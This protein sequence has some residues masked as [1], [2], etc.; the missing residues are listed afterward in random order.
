MYYCIRDMQY[1]IPQV[2]KRGSAPMKPAGFVLIVG[3]LI[4]VPLVVFAQ[5]SPKDL[6]ADWGFLLGEWTANASSGVPGQASKG[7]F[8]LTPDLNG[9]VLVRKNHAEYPAI[10]GRSAIAH[11]DLMVIYR[12]ADVTKAFYDDSEGHVIHYVVTFSPDK[13]KIVFLS[14]KTAGGQQYRLTYEDLRPGIARVL[15]EIAPP[16]SPDQF[17]KYVEATVRR[18]A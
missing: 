9:T 5:S 7:S 3:A 13:K 11:D 16:D 1:P 8:T 12:E 10:G 15:F 18:K 14:E 2:G 17:I 6:W 4:F